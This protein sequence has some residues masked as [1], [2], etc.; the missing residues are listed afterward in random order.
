MAVT[1][2][3]AVL[4]YLRA[5]ELRIGIELT[6]TNVILRWQS[7][8]ILPPDRQLAVTLYQPNVHLDESHDLLNWT[9]KY[10]LAESVSGVPEERQVMLPR[11][12]SARTFY[13]LRR[14]VYMTRFVLAG[15]DL[16]G[17]NLSGAD[18]FAAD[19]RF[20]DLRGAELRGAELRAANLFGARLEGADLT[21]AQLPHPD[22]AVEDRDAELLALELSG[23]LLPP[24]DLYARLHA[25]LE[26]IRTA[27]PD[28]RHIHRR[29]RWAIGELLVSFNEAQL[30]A[31]KEAGLPVPISTEMPKWGC[32]T[33][34]FEKRYNPEALARLYQSQLGIVAAPN[35]MI[36]DG[37]DIVFDPATGEYRFILGWN[38]CEA[39]C[40][41]RHVWVFTVPAGVARLIRE[42]GSPPYEGWQR[43]HPPW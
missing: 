40:I 8:P 17:A 22:C 32:P 6:P 21:G 16:S 4:S 39:G 43:D 20:A 7:R 42:E 10:T 37:N 25:D 19:L 34:R 3:G 2:L 30:Q 33:S 26:A 24:A 9:N 1:G 11:D 14:I 36:G 18:L 27:Y 31:A 28:M 35:W 15:T 12:F 29:A 38:D 41:S 23:E 5:G 13:R